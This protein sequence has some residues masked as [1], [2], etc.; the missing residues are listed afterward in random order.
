MASGA[1][2]PKANK[3]QESKPTNVTP[4][5]FGKGGL[6]R[7]THFL[8]YA[9]TALVEQTT[10]TAITIDDEAASA[11]SSS[12]TS[13]FERLQDMSRG[14]IARWMRGSPLRQCPIR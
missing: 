2:L 5:G 11:S 7:Y 3:K 14:Q 1:R 6:P 12:V 13:C 10:P 4:R 9:A 8:V